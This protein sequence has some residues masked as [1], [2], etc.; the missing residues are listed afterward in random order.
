MP[1]EIPIHTDALG[2]VL[3][4]GDVVA[5]PRS[6]TTIQIGKVVKLNPVL[7]GVNVFKESYRSRYNKKP[8]EM[9]KLED[10]YVTQWLITQE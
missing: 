1:K 9:I 7:V 4:V 2:R 6:A 3:N 10:K 5:I 8:K